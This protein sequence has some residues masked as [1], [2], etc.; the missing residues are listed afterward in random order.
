M[1]DLLNDNT[2]A[3]I[4]SKISKEDIILKTLDVLNDDDSIDDNEINRIYKELLSEYFTEDYLTDTST[5]NPYTPLFDKN[6]HFEG[7]ELT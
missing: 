6:S 4:V 1:Q 2:Y 5:Y 7:D 3:S